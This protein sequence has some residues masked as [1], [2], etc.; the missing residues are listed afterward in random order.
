MHR[1]LSLIA[2]T[3]QLVKQGFE[4]AIRMWIGYGRE[5]F[6]EKWGH[7]DCNLINGAGRKYED[8]WKVSHDW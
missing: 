2:L 5:V 4:K 7:K 1:L 3:N 8:A 6:A